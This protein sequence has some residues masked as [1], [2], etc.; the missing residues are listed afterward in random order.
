MHESLLERERIDRDLKLAEQVQKRFL[1][2]S[3]PVI[4]GFEFFAHYD[5]AYEVGGDYY[6]FVPL[7]GDRLAIAAGRRLGQGGRGRAHD[8]QVFGRHAV[9]HP[10]REFP[11]GGRQRAEHAA[12]LGRASR[13]S[14]S[15]SA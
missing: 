15:P 5:P 11:G 3:V 2:Q 7:P 9:L 1:P 14:S 10:H 4:P 8:G 12:L 6:D 13:R